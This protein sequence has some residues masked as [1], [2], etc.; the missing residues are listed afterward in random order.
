ML[1]QLLP[2]KYCTVQ[3]KSSKT[4]ESYLE[5]RQKSMTDRFS[6]NSYPLSALHWFREKFSL[7]IFE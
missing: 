4:L 1:Q 5:P 6:K 3:T 2:Y 7:S